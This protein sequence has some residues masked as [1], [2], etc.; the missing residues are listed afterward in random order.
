[1]LGHVI[2]SVNSAKMCIYAKACIDTVLVLSLV[3][4]S[5]MSNKEC[6]EES[7]MYGLKKEGC[8]MRV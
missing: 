6:C 8:I 7:W 3:K 4:C 2:L 5:K 1:M